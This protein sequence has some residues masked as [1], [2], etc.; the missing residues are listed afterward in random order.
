MICR[1]SNEQFQTEGDQFPLTLSFSPQET[2]SQWAE[3]EN[4]AGKRI[5]KL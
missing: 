5:P 1:I 3:G 4:R 2:V